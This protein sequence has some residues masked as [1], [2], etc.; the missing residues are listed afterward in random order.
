[1]PLIARLFIKTGLLFFAGALLTGVLSHTA[2][3][4]GFRLSPLFWHMLT[5]GWI[6]QIII[7]VSLWMFPGRPKTDAFKPNITG[8]LSF[9]FLNTGLLLRLGIE[10]WSTDLST[11]VNTTLFIMSALFQLIGAAVYIYEM[12]GRVISPDQRLKQRMKRR[13]RKKQ[14]G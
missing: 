3:G 5:V 7:G 11:S 10:P 9:G 2:L 1:M 14:M 6:T 4:E 8:W 12:W 13:K